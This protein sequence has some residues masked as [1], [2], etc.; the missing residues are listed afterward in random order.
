MAEA[1]RAWLGIPWRPHAAMGKGARPCAP[2]RY[3][4]PSPRRPFVSPCDTTTSP[5]ANT[6]AKLRSIP[7]Q[8]S[9]FYY[10]DTIDPKFLDRS[11]ATKRLWIW[12]GLAT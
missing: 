10:D 12:Q 4:A 9:V 11:W 1:A 2:T 7:M 3:G 6:Y 8:T 5:I